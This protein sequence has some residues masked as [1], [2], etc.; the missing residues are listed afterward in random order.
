VDSLISAYGASAMAESNPLQAYMRDIHAASR[1][2]VANPAANAE[3][4]GRAV[5]GVEPNITEL[6]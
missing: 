6:I 1:H 2:A 4:F 5:L 3:L